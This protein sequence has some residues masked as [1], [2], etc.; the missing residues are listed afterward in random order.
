MADLNTEY[1]KYGS[2]TR[3]RHSVTLPDMTS[4]WTE[5]WTTGRLTNRDPA[6]VAVSRAA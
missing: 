2:L 5:L 1:V 6:P 4:S 3:E